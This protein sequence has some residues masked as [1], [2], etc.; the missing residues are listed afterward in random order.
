MRPRGA[1]AVSVLPLP[2]VSICLLHNCNAKLDITGPRSRSDAPGGAYRNGE[3]SK[4][5]G[6]RY[7]GLL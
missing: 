5:V 7:H 6:C 4:L 2:H 1:E 3:D